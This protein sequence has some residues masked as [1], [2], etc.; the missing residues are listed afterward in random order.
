LEKLGMASYPSSMTDS[1]RKILETLLPTK[2]D[3][4]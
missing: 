2:T 3:T 1:E 4:L